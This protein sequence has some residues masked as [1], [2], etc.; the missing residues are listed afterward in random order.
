VLPAGSF[1]RDGS[2]WFIGGQSQQGPFDANLAKVRMLSGFDVEERVEELFSNSQR[3]RRVGSLAQ[4]AAGTWFFDHAAQRIW[5][6]QDPAT[7]GLIETSVSLFAFGANGVRNVTIENL[8]LEKYATPAQFGAVGG[9]QQHHTMDWTVRNVEARDNHGGGIRI[10]PGMTVEGSKIHRNGQI[11]LAGDGRNGASWLPGAGYSAPVTVRGNEITNN[12]LLNYDWG[13]EGG[14]TKFKY[15]TGMVVENNWV[16]DNR[17][18]G[19]WWDIDNRNVVVRGNLV[20]NNDQAGIFYEISYGTTDIFGNTVRGNGRRGVGHEGA[21]ID[22]SSSSNVTV[23][24]NALEGNRQGVLVRKD[25]R[26]WDTAN[27][28]VHS[29]DIKMTT[30]FTGFRDDINNPAYFTSKGNRFHSNTYR[31]DSQ[32]NTSRFL[33]QYTWRSASGWRSGGQDTDG[34]FLDASGTPTIPAGIPTYTPSTYGT[35]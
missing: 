7:L 20:E 16:H 19:L 25:S 9:W 30:G 17:G 8:V 22:I 32:T 12:R 29:N 26:N 11:G 34:R 33:W 27:V 1:S 13:W 23:R 28:V 31:L 18:P 10:G 2:R 6:G 3:L 14:G 4:V 24:H 35:R 5:I 15:V 21:G